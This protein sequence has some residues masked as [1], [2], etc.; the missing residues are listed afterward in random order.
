MKNI[1]L[2][3]VTLAVISLILTG[4]IQTSPDTQPATPTET[5]ASTVTQTVPKPS[6]AQQ[7]AVYKV[8]VD[9]YYGFR[10]VIDITYK[11]IVYENF[12]LNIN[13]GD[14]VIWVNMDYDYKLTL[15]SDQGL[16]DMNDTRAILISR[17]FNHTFT[18]PGIY[19]FRL[20]E[21]PRTA[22]MTIVVNP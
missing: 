15:V 14:T 17:E 9:D 7:P 8:F 19:T 3:P 5:A 21:E 18:K 10:R 6:Q 13:A 20:K 11:P 4:C 22:P 16:W 1:K 12:T 2:V